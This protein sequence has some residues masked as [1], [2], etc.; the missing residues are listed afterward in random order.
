MDYHTHKIKIVFSV[1]PELLYLCEIMLDGCNT[2]LSELII[3]SHFSHGE[4]AQEYHIHSH[5]V[6]PF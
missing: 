5:L 4:S 6:T 1:H 3:R 2:M